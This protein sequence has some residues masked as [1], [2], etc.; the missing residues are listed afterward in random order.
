MFYFSKL[1][2]AMVSCIGV[3]SMVVF[4]VGFVACAVASLGCSMDLA[5]RY[6]HP[7]GYPTSQVVDYS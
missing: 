6:H 5:A 7:T 4:L 3:K 2:H 1:T